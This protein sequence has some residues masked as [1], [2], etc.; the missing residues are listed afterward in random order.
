MLVYVSHVNRHGLGN[1]L[2]NLT[3]P[4]HCPHATEFYEALPAVA[5]DNIVPL[6]EGAPL[7][8][9]DCSPKLFNIWL[10]NSYVTT[11]WPLLETQAGVSWT[12]WEIPE[13]KE[14]IPVPGSWV[15]WWANLMCFHRVQ[16]NHWL[17]PWPSERGSCFAC[18]HIGDTH[19]MLQTDWS[20]A[21]C[22]WTNRGKMFYNG[23]WPW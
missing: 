5:R 12:W 18:Y 2:C 15:E 6:L 14:V 8:W 19:V 4:L 9:A 10:P 23:P 21:S 16:W 20:P 13:R 11:L 7:T 3:D 22:H 17:M 1:V